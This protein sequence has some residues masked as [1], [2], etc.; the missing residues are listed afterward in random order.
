MPDDAGT[1]NGGEGKEVVGDAATIA[2]LQAKLAD[3]DAKLKTSETAKVE[4]EQRLDEADKELLSE[5]YLSFK[6]N[7]GKGKSVTVT[8]QGGQEID[9]DRASNKEIAAIIQKQYKGDIDAAVKEIKGQLDLSN[10]QIGLIAAQFDVALTA[11][12]HNGSDGKP[13]FEANSKAIFEIAKANPKWGA[14]QCYQQFVLQSKVA[15]DDKAVADKKKAEDDARA[16]TERAG[17]PG[18]AVTGKELSA[19]EAASLAYKK[20]FGDNK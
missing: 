12:K 5:D 1:G 8:T 11:I 15:A 14:E 4:L 18:S 10:R 7:V 9:L 2:D 19:E 13:A 3:R 6:E 20:A 16:A 17:A